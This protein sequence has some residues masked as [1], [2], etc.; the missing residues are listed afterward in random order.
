LYWI[1]F[2]HTVWCIFCSGKGKVVLCFNQAPC[3]EGVLGEWRYSSTQSL[4]SALDGGEWSASRPGRF[5]PRERDPGTHLIGDW[6]GP[7]D[8]L[9]VVVKRKIPS[10]CQELNHRTPI[11][12]IIAQCYTN[13]A[14]MALIFMVWNK[15]IFFIAVAFQLCFGIWY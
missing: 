4:T 12:Q 7:R 9:D 10:P 8:I 1:F 13:W 11:V 15:V 5:T 6:V 14:I 2:F 3:H